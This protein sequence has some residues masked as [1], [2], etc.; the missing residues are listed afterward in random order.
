MDMSFR[1]YFFL[2]AFF[3]PATT[4][5]SQQ[6]IGIQLD[7]LIGGNIS[8]YF[9]TNLG[10]K[11]SFRL[12]AGITPTRRIPGSNIVRSLFLSDP[13]NSN[14]GT[15]GEF[16]KYVVTPEVRAYLG[17]NGAPEGFYGSFFLR[18]SHNNVAVPYSIPFNG[19]TIDTESGLRL[20]VFGGGLGIGY[21]AFFADDKIALDIYVGGGAGYAPL[22]L[23]II[24]EELTDAG[25]EALYAALGE[26]LTIDL[27]PEE[28]PGFLT[29]NGLTIRAPLVLP[30]F[31]SHI[32]LGFVLGR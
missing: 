3:L 23:Q 25:Y 4:V 13:D 17:Q 5:L 21:Q 27:I 2:L 16:T 24:D 22:R 29:N 18:Y 10:E 8:P 9:E 1:S 31:K 12:T 15:N 20:Q 32:G 30:I 19:E 7:N 11:A 6:V 28:L 14:F 26:D